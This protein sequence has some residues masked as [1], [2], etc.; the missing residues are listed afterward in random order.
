MWL[1]DANPDTLSSPLSNTGFGKAFR[2]GLN[3][4]DMTAG[5]DFPGGGDHGLIIEGAFE[6][7]NAVKR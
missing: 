1:E 6:P 3:Q 5:C 4:I 2:E 7:F